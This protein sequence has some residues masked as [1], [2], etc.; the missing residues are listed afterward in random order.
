M[1]KKLFNLF[2]RVSSVLVFLA[3]ALLLLA[4]WKAGLCF[5]AF[6]VVLFFYPKWARWP[7]KRK[8]DFAIPEDRHYVKV[9]CPQCRR[10]LVSPDLRA[11]IPGRE[12]ISAEEAIKLV[13]A[14]RLEEIEDSFDEDADPEDSSF[15]P[16]C[17]S[18]FDAK[19]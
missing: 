13:G 11:A 16:Y 3:G 14:S 15:C 10:M 18:F 12:L 17:S 5:M 19:E 4:D 8:A 1:K 9:R 7:E 6:A 2:V